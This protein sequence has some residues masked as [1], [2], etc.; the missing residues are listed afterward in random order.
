MRSFSALA[1]LCVFGRV[2]AGQLTVDQKIIDFEH[3]AALYAKQYAPYEWKRDV[4]GFDL[5]DTSRWRQRI[6]ASTDD[7]AFYDIMSE[8]VSS[9]NDAHDV[10]TLPSSFVAR[11]HFTVDIYDGKV[12]IDSINRVRLPANEF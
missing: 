8:Y 11:L 6:E 4:Q 12:L 1:L 5:L 9:L 10:Y 2:S 7:L 3:L